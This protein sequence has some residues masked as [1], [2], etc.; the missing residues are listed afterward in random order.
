M[1][2]YNP[3]AYVRGGAPLNVARAI[4]TLG[5]RVRPSRPRRTPQPPRGVD[6]A[7]VIMGDPNVVAGMSDIDLY[8]GPAR[9]EAD[10][11]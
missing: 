8:R 4:Q 2:P 7:A 1:P 3:R 10:R 9:E 6:W 5:R 11:G